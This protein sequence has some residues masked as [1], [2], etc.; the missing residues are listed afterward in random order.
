MRDTQ[1]SEEV[2]SLT[3]VFLDM[4]LCKT[5]VKPKYLHCLGVACFLVASKV[6]EEDFTQP[7]LEELEANSGF[8]FTTNDIKRMERIVCTKL[9]WEVRKEL[10]C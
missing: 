4:F 7:S 9:N 10:G 1:F 6:V 8:A 3:C 2:F 5:K